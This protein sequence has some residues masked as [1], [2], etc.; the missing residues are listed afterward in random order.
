[1]ADHFRWSQAQRVVTEPH[2]PRTTPASGGQMIGSSSPARISAGRG[3]SLAD[4]SGEVI[5]ANDGVPPLKS[6]EQANSVAADPRPAHSGGRSAGDGR[7][8][9]VFGQDATLGRRCKKRGLAP[10][11]GQSRGGWK[12]K[13]QMLADAPAALASFRSRLVRPPISRPPTT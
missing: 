13:A 9:F 12:T 3:V 5:D 7:D 10:G 2:V 8:R 4:T 1:M 6:P 11:H